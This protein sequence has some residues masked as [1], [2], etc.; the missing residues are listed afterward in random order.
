MEV[1]LN[2]TIAH[3]EELKAAGVTYSMDYSRTGADGTADCSGAIYASLRAGGASKAAWVLN[4]EGLHAWLIDNGFSLIADNAGFNAKRGDVF[5]WGR[6]GAS[7]GAG[8]HTGIFVDS[9]RIIH[10]NY[11][12]N[13]VSINNYNQVWAADG[14]PYFYIYR[15]TKNTPD[16]PNLITVK[17]QPGYGVLAVNAQGSLIPNLN[18]TLKHDTKWH[19]SGIY[20]LNGRAVYALG[21]DL[22]GWYIFQDYTDQAGKVTINYASGYG[23]NAVD[24]NWNQIEG[25]NSKFKAGTSWKYSRIA[26]FYGSLYYQVSPKEYIP[27]CYANGSGYKGTEADKLSR[28]EDSNAIKISFKPGY[29][30]NA[31]NVQGVQIPNSNQTLK[32]GTMWHSNAIY[33]LNGHPAYALGEQLPGWLVYQDYTDQAGKITINY[34]KGFGINAV[35]RYGNPIIGTNQK[36]KAGTQWKYDSVINVGGTLYYKVSNFEYIPALYTKGSG[37][38]A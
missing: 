28:P 6:K 20:M 19:S 22:P 11:S 10:C 30:V 16:D 13:G 21:G 24:V 1:D 27:A 2:K 25:T 34:K 5:I 17:Y 31:I 8:G 38:Q 7:A 3:M 12:S 32:H 37:Y 33:L 26:N 9:Q 29:G 4:T 15:L 35:D 36:F 18:Q 14:S 23:V